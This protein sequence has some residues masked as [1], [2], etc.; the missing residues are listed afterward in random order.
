MVEPGKTRPPPPKPPPMP[1]GPPPRSATPPRSAAP[2]KPSAD[3]PASG[4]TFGPSAANSEVTLKRPTRRGSK[5]RWLL[6][7]VLVP[8]LLLAALFLAGVH[9]GARHP[10]MWLSRTTLWMFDREP[11]LELTDEDREPLARKLRLLVLP[12]VEHSMEVDV[13]QAEI[14]EIA[15]AANLTRETIDCVTACR[16]LW[17]AKH[18]DLEFFEVLHC[19]GMPAEETSL[20]K[21]GHGKL[22]CTATVQRDSSS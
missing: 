9:V 10:Q 19:K 1:K 18:P 6:G 3:R 13:T 4:P 22:E 12:R 14:D 17:L 8:L 15:K 11:Q 21:A 2:S 20:A 7:W 16:S 5:L